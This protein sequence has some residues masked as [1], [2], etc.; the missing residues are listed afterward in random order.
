MEQLKWRQITFL[1]S[2]LVLI[3]LLLFI[4]L[5]LSPS[6][7]LRTH[8]FMDGH[9]IVAL[10]TKIVDDQEHNQMDK[11]FLRNEHAK[12]YSL[13]KPPKDDL[14]DSF[15]QNYIVRKKGF[16]YIANYYGNA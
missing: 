14:T 13:T 10:T 1:F 12:C 2:P 11:E 16:I 5:H 4:L 7:A 6:I 9:P 15:L 8:V 3:P